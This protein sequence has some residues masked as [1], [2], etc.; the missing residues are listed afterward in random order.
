MSIHS[1][2]TLSIYRK[3]M[4]AI[5]MLLSIGRIFEC[6]LLNYCSRLS[7]ETISREIQ[8]PNNCSDICPDANSRPALN[9]VCNL[10]ALG[11]SQWFA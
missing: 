5:L 1:L 3:L 8:R 7:S 4:E 2:P 9:L 10:Y 6:F 11:T